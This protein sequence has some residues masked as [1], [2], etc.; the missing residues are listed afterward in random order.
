VLG[1][2]TLADRTQ[3]G[4]IQLTSPMRFE[5]FFSSRSRPMRGKPREWDRAMTLRSTM[6]RDGAILG[7][8]HE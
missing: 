8:G 1:A 5:R 7:I 3:P 2:Q 4:F 6:N